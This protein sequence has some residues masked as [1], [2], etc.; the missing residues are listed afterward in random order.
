M[1]YI[2]KSEFARQHGFSKQYVTELIRKGIIEEE[3]NGLLNS[4]KSDH[5]L[6]V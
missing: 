6:F 3:E 4:E 2:T 1:T 5:N